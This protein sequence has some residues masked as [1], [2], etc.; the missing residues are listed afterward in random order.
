MV[1]FMVSL[2]SHSRL[3]TLALSEPCLTVVDLLQ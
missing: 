3:Q 2:N 1:F